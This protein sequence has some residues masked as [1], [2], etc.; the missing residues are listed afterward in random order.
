MIMVAIALMHF[1][2]G[3]PRHFHAHFLRDAVVGQHRTEGVSQGVK[4]SA[5]KIPCPFSLHY[6]EVQARPHDDALEYLGQSMV[7]R[8]L[9]F[10]QRPAQRTKR[11]GLG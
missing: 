1:S 3:M 7:S 6:S 5:G 4:S 8:L 10:G 2:R 9:R 11:V